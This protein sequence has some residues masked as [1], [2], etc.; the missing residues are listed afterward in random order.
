MSNARNEAN[1]NDLQ[2][3]IDT[4]T[5]FTERNM[6]Q[7]AAEARHLSVQNLEAKAQRVPVMEPSVL[8][9]PQTVWQDGPASRTRARANV[10]ASQH[11]LEKALS[12][13]YEFNSEY[14]SA[15]KL[16][17]RK[18]PGKMFAAALAVMDAETGDML[19]YR[20]IINHPNPEVAGQ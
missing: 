6:S 7:A 9:V 20:Q 4:T 12:A 10:S 2:R 17:G 13:A 16:A 14:G 5:S 11:A 18:F 3:L 1:L 19:K 15:Q 8:R